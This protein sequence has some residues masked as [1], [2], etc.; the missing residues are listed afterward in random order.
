MSHPRLSAFLAL[1]LAAGAALGL[2]GCGK[3]Q[4]AFKT[5]STINF[6]IL[7]AENQ[8]SMGP[9][10][11]PLLDDM[12]KQT[13][14][15]V[16]AYYASNYTSLIEAMRFNQVQAGWFS[17]LPALEAVNRSNAEVLGRVVDAGGEGTYESVLIVRKGS[18][19]SLD[20]VLKCGKRYSFGIGDAQST[21]GTLAP[22]AFLF[23]PKGIEPSEC[24][25][26]VRSASHQANLFS[27]ANG[28]VDVATNNTVG[29]VFARRENPALAAKVQ[30]IWTSQPLP[31]SSIL[32]RKDL[33]PV[34][35]EKIRSFFLSYGT[36]DGPDAAR[37]RKVLAGLTYGGFVPADSSYL[38][39]VREMKAS[40][41][42][43]EARRSGNRGK[44]AAAQQA[45]S[46]IHARTL[47]AA[48]PATLR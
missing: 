2:V 36:G 44:I 8:Q 34:I 29:L 25:K 32:A 26:A 47:V 9:L 37:Q 4:P 38:D 27:V 1:T 23:T 46:R 28:V 22:M 11:Q 13:G 10:W 48:P 45:Y 41:A 16:K 39:P 43:S 33:D 42:L 20:G 17:A 6:S 12:S 18:G 7:S 35:K 3:P 24:F 14:L 40:H 15:T 19:I 31:E 21:S 5:P 30:V